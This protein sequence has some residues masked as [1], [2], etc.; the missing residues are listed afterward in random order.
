[1]FAQLYS[2]VI[3][4]VNMHSD[5]KKTPAPRN[6]FALFSRYNHVVAAVCCG[7]L[8]IGGIF[9]I[10]QYFKPVSQNS[11]G[12]IQAQISNLAPHAPILVED[13]HNGV[14]MIKNGEEA[15]LAAGKYRIKA[16]V[17]GVGSVDQEVVINQGKK[18]VVDVDLKPGSPENT[19]LATAPALTELV[20]NTEV[21]STAQLEKIGR[22]DTITQ[23][24][25][26]QKN[27]QN[28]DQT[29]PALIQTSNNNSDQ[30]STLTLITPDGSEKTLA[31]ECEIYRTEFDSSGE[32]LRYFKTCPNEG[33]NGFY[34]FNIK[35]KK[36]TQLLITSE[37]V[38]MLRT[39]IH[40]A[41]QEMVFT[42]PTGEFGIV[43]DGKVE[44][45]N[46]SA[47]FSAPQFSP[48][49]TYLLV[50]DNTINKAQTDRDPKQ[51][52]SLYEAY[53]LTIKKVLWQ[54][55]LQNKSAAQFQEVGQ[56]YYVPR[57]DDYNFD[58]WSW[59]N[60][61][62]YRVGDSSRIFS[63]SGATQNFTEDTGSDAGRI[64]TGKNGVKYR[65]YLGKLS[66]LDGT[67]VARDVDRVIEI[68]GNLY[69]MIYS[70]LFRLSDAGLTQVY[71][72]KIVYMYS[73]Q[74]SLFVIN[75][76]GNLLEY[77][78]Q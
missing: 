77:Q 10:T 42:K 24:V 12:S 6:S 46:K 35:D 63:L 72:Q 45:I 70:F 8:G 58:F 23:I 37:A 54:D 43:Q 55:L 56:T 7:V 26:A 40:P 74:N 68:Q 57:P 50:L 4:V 64:Y 41:T 67:L 52:P 18:S 31:R 11:K 13:E 30:T 76:Q 60:E 36:E 33:Q 15:E 5:P 78:V 22:E 61:D 53:G 66:T 28:S 29:P 69:F 62:S 73:K 9:L 21:V 59:I 27:F 16:R 1:M 20:K 38:N 75:Q 51:I 3:L 71:P 14:K 25:P 32:N 34:N 39:D 17:D 44:V 47:N 2:L 65:L 19:A 49:G 48:D